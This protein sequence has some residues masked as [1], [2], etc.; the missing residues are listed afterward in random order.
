MVGSLLGT[1]PR[2]VT[3]PIQSGM[4]AVL[5]WPPASTMS[6][7]ESAMGT[8]ANTALTAGWP[9]AAA[10]SEVDPH[11]GGADHGDVAVAPRLLD[12]PVE[13]LGVVGHGALAPRV[14]LTAGGAGATVVEGH[15]GVPVLPEPACTGAEGRGAQRLAVAGDGEGRGHRSAD[16][17][18]QVHVGAQDDAVGHRDGEVA[19]DDLL[20][21]DGL[22][23]VR[24]ERP[25]HSPRAHPIRGSEPPPRSQSASPGEWPWP[26][27]PRRG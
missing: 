16:A 21:G 8:V 18:R 5:I 11:V 13:H 14:P 20:G 7:N 26:A 24:G 9:L 2:P 12:D 27:V 4:K 19:E 23:H 17:R 1:R 10:N 3:R 6:R 15:R 22:G 25:P